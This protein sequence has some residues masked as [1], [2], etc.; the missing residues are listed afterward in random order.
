MRIFFIAVL[1][2]LL[3]VAGC[4][5]SPATSPTVVPTTTPLAT[6]TTT[7]PEGPL[8]GVSV[9]PRSMNALDFSSFV[10]QAAASLDTVMWAGDWLELARPD[11]GGPTVIASLGKKYGFLPLAELS[12]HHDGDL[13]RPL[14]ES[15]RQLLLS[16][17]VNYVSMW[18][19]KYLGIG[20]E[21]NTLYEKHP[22]DFDTFVDAF[23]ATAAAVRAASPGTKVFTCFQLEKMKGYSI[24]QNTPPDPAMAE[25]DLVSRF[26]ADLI[27]FTTYPCLVFKDPS[28]ISEDYYTGIADHV[29]KP[30]IFTEIGWY[31][32]ASPEGWESSDAEQ[33]AFVQRFPALVAPLDPDLLI[34]S[35]MYDQAV[36]APFDTMGLYRADGSARP[37]A[38]LWLRS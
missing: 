20:I 38:A 6:A 14:D 22:A 34:W 1:L 26:D 35:F 12:V 36:M 29:D 27:A 10:K 37:A 7:G 13:V 24:W 18:H 33:A 9:S 25:W 15:N 21:V 8:R 23:N 5:A 11:D 4:G 17:A 28:E 2:A 30:V 32:A 19:P 3:A 16:S 31:A